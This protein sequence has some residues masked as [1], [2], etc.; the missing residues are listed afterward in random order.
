MFCPCWY[1]VKELMVMDR[2]WCNTTQWYLIEGGRSAEVE[3]GTRTVV[4]TMDFPGPTLFDGDGTGRLYIDDGASAE[5][6]RELEGIFQGKKGGAPELFGNIVAHWLPTKQAS[7]AI[8]K[9][10]KTT[11]SV[12][13]V[14]QVES[15]LLK[16][17][18]GRVM[19]V[20]AQQAG[21]QAIEVAELVGFAQGRMIGDVVGDP[22]EFVE[23]HDRP[24][25]RRGNQPGGHREILVPRALA[26]SMLCGVQCHGRLVS[27]TTRGMRHCREPEPAMPAA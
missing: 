25:V 26:G 18:A 16:D 4:L 11:A 1:A 24:P 12:T 10:D 20:A 21:L 8:A 7:I 22:H 17:D 5:Q 13:G 23:C 9:G 19:I 27:Q 6:S 14:G 15:T 2:G 3:L